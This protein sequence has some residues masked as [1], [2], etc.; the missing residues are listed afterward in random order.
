MRLLLEYVSQQ[1]KDKD[2]ALLSSSSRKGTLRTTTVHW[3]LHIRAES[4][5]PPMRATGIPVIRK[6]QDDILMT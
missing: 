2:T 1:N 4:Q 5:R 3:E 6:K